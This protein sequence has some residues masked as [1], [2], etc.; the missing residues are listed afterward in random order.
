MNYVEENYDEIKEKGIALK[1]AYQGV[2]S[3]PPILYNGLVYKP[4]TTKVRKKEKLILQ[5]EKL[6]LEYLAKIRGIFTYKGK[7]QG[8][9]YQYVQG[10]LLRDWLEKDMPFD[11]RQKLIE[12]LVLTDETLIS[13]GLNYFDY[14]T[15]NML[16]RDD[17]KLIDIDSI[18]KINIYNRLCTKRFLFDLII[19]IYANYDITFNQDNVPYLGIMSDF[20]DI[21]CYDELNFNEILNALFKKSNGEDRVLRERIKNF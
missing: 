1:N 9:M 2:G 5:L 18:T 10:K 6:N 7:V 16:V 12:E 19:S 11:I 20:L 21:N 4:F 8:Y 14:H 15:A 17:I 13:N 3:N